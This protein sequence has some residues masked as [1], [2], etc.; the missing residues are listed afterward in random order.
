M[1]NNLHH[2][3]EVSV[4]T[5]RRDCKQDEEKILVKD[6]MKS[7]SMNSC[8]KFKEIPIDDKTTFHVRIV[9]E[10]GC[11]SEYAGRGNVMFFQK[12]SLQRDICLQKWVIA[13]ELFHVLGFQHEMN[14]PDRDRY[15]N[16]IWE[17]IDKKKNEVQFERISLSNAE[18]FDVAY[19]YNSIMHYHAYTFAIN[20]NKPSILPTDP[21]M[22]YLSI[23][24]GD[25]PTEMDYIKLNLL[26]DCKSRN[27][28]ISAWTKWGPCLEYADHTYHRIRQRFCSHEDVSEC[29]ELIEKRVQ[30]ERKSCDEKTEDLATWNRW[31]T[32]SYCNV[33]PGRIFLPQERTRDCPKK[34]RCWGSSKQSRPCRTDETVR[35]QYNSLNHTSLFLLKNSTL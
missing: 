9:S 1:S 6:V 33:L 10:I 7:I 24:P 3:F 8:V 15:V 2:N 5:R 28:P 20:K 4:L 13:H 25:K 17:N 19:E 27:T 35:G 32:W 23:G 12:L 11:A 30:T 16:I 21:T 29:W 34:K 26:Y 18:T 22:S 31:S 14:R